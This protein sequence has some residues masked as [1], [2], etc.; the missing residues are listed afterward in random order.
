MQARINFIFVSI[1]NE[2]VI[3]TD[4]IIAAKIVTS[5]FRMASSQRPLMLKKYFC[6][7]K[8]NRFC[9]IQNHFLG[10]SKYDWFKYNF[11]KWHNPHKKQPFYLIRIN[12]RRMCQV[13]TPSGMCSVYR[14]NRLND[15]KN[16][17]P[18]EKVSSLT[19]SLTF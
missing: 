2:K 14:R 9:N 6:H 13:T 7:L 8:G 4:N 17:I 19:C 5:F 18:S 3:K 11:I 10:N 16:T 1:K 12:R 15:F